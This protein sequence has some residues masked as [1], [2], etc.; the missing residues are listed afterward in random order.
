MDIKTVKKKEALTK[1]THNPSTCTS[2]LGMTGKK[3]PARF[4]KDGDKQTR[5]PITISKMIFISLVLGGVAMTA[6]LR[7]FDGL[8]DIKLGLDGGRV[9]IDGRKPALSP[10]ITDNTA[11]TK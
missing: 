10:P 3:V 6:I 9:L 7:G 8:I 11:D 1:I 4:Y 2:Q 5:S